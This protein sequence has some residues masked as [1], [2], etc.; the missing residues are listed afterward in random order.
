MRLRAR[1]WRLSAGLTV[2]LAGVLAVP[3]PAGAA[4]DIAVS[5]GYAGLFVPGRHV[6]VSVRVSADR[7]LRGT[8]EVTVRPDGNPDSGAS[9]VRLPVEVPGASTKSFLLVAPPAASFGPGGAVVSARLVGGGGRSTA[10][11]ASQSLRSDP[12]Q[13]LVG[14]LP[15]PLAG[16]RPPPAV[17][18]AVDAG[19][20]H[21]VELG[22]PEL[23]QAPASLAPLGTIAAA[24]NDLAALGDPIRLAL[25]RWLA[26]GGT[27]LVDAAPGQAVEGLPREWQPGPGGYAPA[28]MGRVRL[29]DGAMAAGSW[30]RLIEPT[31][32]AGAAGEGFA[33]FVGPVGSIGSA[34]AVDAGLRVPP[35]GWLLAFLV[36][37]VVVVGP[38]TAVVLRRRRRSELAWL[39]IPVVAL[40]FTSMSYAGARQVRG[41]TRLAHG[42]TLHLDAG[43][44]SSTTFVG[45]A[46]R[47]R[48]TREISLP[49]A[50]TASANPTTALSRF[51]G[52]LSASSMDITRRGPAARLEL[53]AGQF[54]VAS[55]AGPGG[56]SGQLTVTARSAEDGHAAGNVRNEMPYAL[57][58]AA[59]FVGSSGVSLGRLE[60][61]EERPWRLAAGERPARGDVHDIGHPMEPAEFVVWAEST[62]RFG[63]IDHDSVVN[64][65][66]WQAT[67]GNL[68]T[69]R[70]EGVAVAVGWTR[71]H[72]PALLVDGERR[73][74]VGRTA[75]V[76]R[77]PVE[78]AGRIT[79]SSVRTEVVRGIEGNF[80]GDE[81]PR[82]VVRST[83]PGGRL[84]ASGLVAGIFDIGGPAP[85]VWLDGRWQ[86]LQ[87]VAGG[88]H[89]QEPSPEPPGA[90]AVPVPAPPA[91]V[92]PPPGGPPPPGPGPAPP[93]AVRL[94]PGVA[95]VAGVAGVVGP[96]GAA[97]RDYAVPDAAVHHGLVFLRLARMDPTQMTVSLREAVG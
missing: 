21:L 55:A 89:G 34:L 31:P 93:P 20:A 39:V 38:V 81:A 35:I 6:P 12:T 9:R 18:L 30:D 64:F 86:R 17:P 82:V 94:R 1:A 96:G 13:E 19:V 59:V 88:P 2:V 44:T 61:G 69:P 50:W 33:A 11:S 26:D 74:P 77:A 41:A 92:A 45:I 15:G 83:L 36:V 28:G 56:F 90:R 53:G 8:L 68:S 75:V 80:R 91:T 78:P 29:T 67:A 40:I 70:P 14:I 43:G 76:A 79:S 95:G 23:A 27:L 84:P 63:P 4:T 32:T 66:L 10:T 97:G 49:G 25:L 3:V 51:S 73:R 65:P 7:L 72:A 57:E 85:E 24:P 52:S 62:G 16:A 71:Q 22:R 87:P 46:A 58:Q 5:G 54:A 37:Y 42:T 60:P 48:E 47:G